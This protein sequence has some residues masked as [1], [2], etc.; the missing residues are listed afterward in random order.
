MQNEIDNQGKHNMKAV[1]TV[2]GILPGTIR[3]WEGR[4]RANLSEWD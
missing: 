4:Y 2:V 3:A 1:S